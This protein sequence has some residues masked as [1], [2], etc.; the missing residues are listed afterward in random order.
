MKDD[1]NPEVSFVG[2]FQGEIEIETLGV[3]PVDPFDYVQNFALGGLVT[4]LIYYENFV[5]NNIQF[6]SS[7]SNDSLHLGAIP[8]TAPNA[9]PTIGFSGPNGLF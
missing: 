7:I 9:F 1:G 6:N 4:E 5:F 3:L 8:P 2:A